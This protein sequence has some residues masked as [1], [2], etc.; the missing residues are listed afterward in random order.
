V[1]SLVPQAAATNPPLDAVELVRQHQ[2]G[3][4][5]YL[6]ALGA[7]PAEAEDLAQETLVVALRT[8]PREQ[9]PAA[10]AAYL[11][12][13]GRN[14]F[15]KDRRRARRDPELLDQAA[16]DACFAARCGEDGGV[17]YVAAL[18]GCV[19]K[20]DARARQALQRHYEERAGRR[21][22]AADFGLGR[23]GVKSWL[24][25]IRAELRACVQRS[26]GRTEGQG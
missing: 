25:R 11:R 23:D 9:A 2:V 13:V 5:R 20:L 1:L 4:W 15:L 22:M 8:P 16:L 3:L 21:A 19:A 18:R 7:Q 6:R 12:S 26:L 24:R 17:A 14:L 10:V